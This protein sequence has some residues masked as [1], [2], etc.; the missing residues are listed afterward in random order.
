MQDAV[1][2]SLGPDLG[3][4]DGASFGPGHPNSTLASC[5]PYQP[6]PWL[7][8]AGVNGSTSSFNRGMSLDV[9][10]HR[11]SLA[12]LPGFPGAA[13]SASP[14]TGDWTETLIAL[15][16]RPGP[17]TRTAAPPGQPPDAPTTRQTAAA[18]QRAAPP[19]GTTIHARPTVS[20][21]SHPKHAAAATRPRHIQQSPN[22]PTR[23]PADTRRAAS[24]S[25]RLGSASGM[26]HADPVLLYA[27]RHEQPRR[28]VITEVRRT[29]AHAE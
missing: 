25:T 17:P 10:R 23:S 3:D 2:A 21:Y 14:A 22:R 6:E 27:A 28:P 5:M 11:R 24:C 9:A 7:G 4:E 29:Y 8:V 12:P 26:T 18:T 1:A 19:A 13:P 20:H 15:P 16:V